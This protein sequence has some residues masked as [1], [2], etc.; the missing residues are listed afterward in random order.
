M[1]ILEHAQQFINLGIAVIP[2]GYK[3]KRPDFKLI[4]TW[5]P[6]KTTPPTTEQLTQ[7][8]A[9]GDHNYGVVTG[10]GNLVVIDFDDASEYRDWMRWSYAVGGVATYISQHAYRVS[11]SRG[12]HVYVRLPHK[13]K[14]RKVG[15]KIDI[16]ADGYV[17]GPGSIHPSGAEYRAL[18]EVFNFPVV[19][20]L[21]DVLP[22]SL[23]LNTT[24]T[25][26]NN[27]NHGIWTVPTPHT[28]PAGGLIE[29]IKKAF[30]IEGIFPDIHKSGDHWLLT[31][32][33]LHDDHNPSMW[34]DTKD[35]ICGCFAGCTDKPLDVI[36]LTARIHGLSNR[37]TIFYLAER[38]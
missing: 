18:R 12:F 22:T 9:T 28:A 7:W 26:Q 8:F 29:R 36:N 31:Q 11:T 21:S 37:E 6:Y 3:D 23:L 38:L 14:N 20:A 13:E 25:V 34:I 35:Q 15:T 16:K 30:P 17:L 5:E 27:Q 1:T 10:W 32:C 4:H 2:I 19:S 24:K 33:P